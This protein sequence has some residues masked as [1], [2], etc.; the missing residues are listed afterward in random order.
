MSDCPVEAISACRLIVSDSPGASSRS[1]LGCSRSASDFS[2]TEKDR[3]SAASFETVTG[4]RLLRRERDRGHRVEDQAVHDV[5]HAPVDRC[6]ELDPGIGLGQELAGLGEQQHRVEPFGR[7]A[8]GGQHRRERLDAPPRLLQRRDVRRGEPAERRGGERLRRARRIGR[9]E[10]DRALRGE[11]RRAGD[12]Q[13]E[14]REERSGERRVL[15]EHHGDAAF[16]TRLFLPDR[17]EVAEHDLDARTGSVPTVAPSSASAAGSGTMAERAPPSSA[18]VAG[19]ANPSGCSI[20]ATVPGPT[21]NVV[22]PAPGRLR[23]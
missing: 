4:S 22:T 18:V 8:L 11:P 3:A 7:C 23:R 1:S 6:D 12:V 21:S 10:L 20:G 2:R 16:L 9:H 19:P 13:G 14:R 5:L 15:A 17:R